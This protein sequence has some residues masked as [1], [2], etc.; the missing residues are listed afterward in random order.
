MALTQFLHCSSVQHFEL[1]AYCFMPDH[2]HALVMGLTEGADF[3]QF[4]RLAKQRSGYLFAQ[5]SG[6]KLWQD[7]YWERILREDQGTEEVIQYIVGNP[8][9]AG[10]VNDARHYPHWGSQ[11]HSRDE[12]LEFVGTADLKVRPP[13]VLHRD[14]HRDDADNGRQYNAT[15]GEARP[16]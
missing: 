2:L 4:V 15:H 5:V 8:V 10:L 7:G 14:H 11:I 6:R 3:T 9:R 13:S 12:I 16:A 1:S